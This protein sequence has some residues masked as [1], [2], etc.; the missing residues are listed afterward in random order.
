MDEQ[1]PHMHLIFLPVVHTKDKKGN[2]LK[3]RNNP[4]FHPW[5][6]LL[7]QYIQVLLIGYIL[8][9]IYQNLHNSLLQ[10]HIV[11]LQYYIQNH[12]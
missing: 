12:Q 1:S 3:K 11:Y 5:Y 8:F 6:L 9:S 2:I 7:W 10:I 4:I